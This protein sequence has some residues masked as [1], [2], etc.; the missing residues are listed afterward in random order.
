MKPFLLMEARS[1]DGPAGMVFDAVFNTPDVG[2]NAPLAPVVEPPSEPLVEPPSDPVGP[3]KEEV[4]LD[5][6]QQPQK[7]RNVSQ[8]E[9]P[10]VEVEPSVAATAAPTK[11]VKEEPAA[12]QTPIPPVL[13]IV[14]VSS[15]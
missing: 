6:E 12:P 8:P 7:M 13:T 2:A 3:P 14:Q 5:I 11:L 15:V 10:K 4:R 9:F 1:S